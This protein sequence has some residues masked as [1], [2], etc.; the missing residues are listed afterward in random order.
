MFIPK[1]E[2]GQGLVEYALILVLVAVVIILILTALGSSVFVV[3]ARVTGGLT[4]QSIDNTGVEYIVV[5][6]D[7]TV[8]GSGSACRVAVDSAQFVALE[9][10]ELLDEGNMLFRYSVNG[11][12]QPSIQVPLDGNLNDAGPFQV[13]A[14]CPLELTTPHG[15]SRT[16]TVP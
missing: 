1:Q 13:T 15:Y 7:A 4:G 16:F 5:N 2:D 11:H 14:P 8:T 6:M 12:G 10:G 9:D 3:Y